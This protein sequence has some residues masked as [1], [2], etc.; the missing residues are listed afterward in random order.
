MFY[1]K[2][3]LYFFAPDF[4]FSK[5]KKSLNYC[6]VC[7]CEVQE[8]AMRLESTLTAGFLNTDPKNMVIILEIMNSMDD[9]NNT[10]SIF[11][12]NDISTIQ[13]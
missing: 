2:A 5:A 3:L 9:S 12:I 1:V 10:K 11:N 13:S 6:N 7:Q 8:S 4:N